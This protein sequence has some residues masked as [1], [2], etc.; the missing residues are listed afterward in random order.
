VRWLTA[1]ISASDGLFRRLVSHEIPKRT[2]DLSDEVRSYDSPATRQIYEAYDAIDTKA[3]A[4][5]QHVSIMTAVAGVLFQ[6][7]ESALFKL[8]F[9]F[10]TSLYIILALFCLRLLMVH[11]LGPHLSDQSDVAAKEALLALTSK[12]TFLISVILV[13]VVIAELVSR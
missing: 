6:T 1:A 11:H 8:I 2:K 3:A 13:V 10:E 9:G 4:I 5:L 7:T 12:F